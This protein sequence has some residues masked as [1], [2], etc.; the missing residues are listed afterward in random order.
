MHFPGVPLTLPR[1]NP[2]HC[3]PPL[4]HLHLALGPPSRRLYV[5]SMLPVQEPPS[6]APNYPVPFLVNRGMIA[7]YFPMQPAPSAVSTS[8]GR[9]YHSTWK[10]CQTITMP[11]PTWACHS[12]VGNALKPQLVLPRGYKVVN[13]KATESGIDW[14]E[15]HCPLCP[16]MAR[17]RVVGSQGVVKYKVACSV[18]DPIPDLGRDR[19]PPCILARV[20]IRYSEL[21]PESCPLRF[22]YINPETDV[23]RPVRDTFLGSMI[24][25]FSTQRKSMKSRH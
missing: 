11:I 4:S 22:L 23:W 1:G 25:Y 6:F 2:V 15:F 17:G 13:S 3:G 12:A 24:L 9:P 8:S 14:T 21:N 20:L 19:L 10:A 7:L 5:S 18:H 16:A